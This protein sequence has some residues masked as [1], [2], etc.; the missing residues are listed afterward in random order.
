M[1]FMPRLI[2]AKLRARI[3]ERLV[4]Y[5]SDLGF[6][7]RYRRK[8]HGPAERVHDDRGKGVWVDVMLNTRSGHIY[9]AKDVILGHDCKLLTGRHEYADG[10]LKPRKEQVPDSGYDIHIGR[11]AWIASGAIVLGGVTVGAH[12][13][14]AAG[15]VVTRDVPPNTIVGGNPAKPIGSTAAEA[16]AD[17]TSTSSSPR[18][19][20]SA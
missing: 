9:L 5:L 2:P 6:A 13:I 18:R 12:S 3:E 7:H 1:S 20:N 15:A 4:D 8:V 19:A 11:G 17:G 10:K 16:Q 14:V